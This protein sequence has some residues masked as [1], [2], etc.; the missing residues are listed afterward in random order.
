MRHISAFQNPAISIRHTKKFQIAVVVSMAALAFAGCGSKKP[1]QPIAATG[2]TGSTQPTGAQGASTNTQ[3]TEPT[4]AAANPNGAGTGDE[5][6]AR[7]GVKI[8][9]KNGGLTQSTPRKVHV[10][11]YIPVELDIAVAD[12]QTYNLVVTADGR[13]R[14]VTYDKPG[15]YKLTIAG[16]RSNATA[17]VVLG[18]S[19]TVK[20]TADANPGP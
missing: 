17:T 8:G 11:S 15:A 10:P 20:I 4:A 12:S 7:T 19:E 6:P 3:A 9:L 14:A 5:Q 1:A 2:A 18:G 13:N 16:L